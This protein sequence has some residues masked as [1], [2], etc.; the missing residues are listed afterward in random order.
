MAVK[1]FVA[2]DYNYGMEIEKGSK[3][4]PD[5]RKSYGWKPGQAYL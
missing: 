4:W 1:R 2:G 5:G 3:M